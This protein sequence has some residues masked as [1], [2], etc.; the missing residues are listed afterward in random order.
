[1]HRYTKLHIELSALARYV[2]K[3][4][5]LNEKST[6]DA[7]EHYRTYN[8]PSDFWNAYDKL[9]EEYFNTKPPTKAELIEYMHELGC[10]HREI[11]ERLKSSPNTIVRVLGRERQLRYFKDNLA[12]DM[13]LNHWKPYRD[14]YPDEFFIKYLHK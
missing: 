10:S 5:T 14:L 7:F 3:L 4:H 9:K 6:V 13:L 2:R 11:Q 8:M 1:M 12:L